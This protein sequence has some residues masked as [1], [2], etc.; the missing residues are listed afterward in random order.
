MRALA[1]ALAA[2]V[3]GPA[4]AQQLPA[5]DARIISIRVRETGLIH[6]GTSPE[7]IQTILFSQSERIASVVLS[8]P[9][10]FMVNVAGTS[11]SLALRTA[12]PSAHAVMTVRTDVRTYDFELVSGELRLA[13]PV[14]RLTRYQEYK[15]PQ[16]RTPVA[17]T[18]YRLS[19]SKALR[20]TA[21]SDDGEKTFIEWAGDRAMP[22]TFALGPTGAEQMV[23]GYMRDGK[24]TIDRVYPALIFR[25]DK[26]A[27][28]AIRLQKKDRHG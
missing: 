15:L 20:P 9:T 21:I 27:A 28:R 11:D 24:F 5:L 14:I 4:G 6:I 3:A 7:V 23:D 22:A 2:L 16:Q 26:Q 10:A 8:D 12:G 19:G 25:I 1:I 17:Q 18:S 13:P